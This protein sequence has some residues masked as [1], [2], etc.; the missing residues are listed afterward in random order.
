MSQ[1]KWDSR[2]ITTLVTSPTA[3]PVSLTEAK[4]HLRVTT[5]DDD[6]YIS[7]LITVARKYI[8]EANSISVI[9]QTWDYWLNWFPDEIELPRSPLSSITSITYTDTD[10][11]EQTL[12]TSV[13]TVDSDSLPGRVYEAFNQS[14]PTTRAIPKAI[15]IRFVG[16]YSAA[17]SG[18]PSNLTQA[19]LLMIGHWYES[20]EP[21]VVGTITSEIPLAAKALMAPYKMVQI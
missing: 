9:N 1:S 3:E 16:G 21:I 10:G 2:L 8:E 14:W 17:A 20:R 5:T 7:A 4:D 11:A 12:A 18:V 19:I 15:K 13:Y 6:T